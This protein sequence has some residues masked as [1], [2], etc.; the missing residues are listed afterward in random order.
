M[1]A[2]QPRLDR[3]YSVCDRV[4][5]GRRPSDYDSTYRWGGSSDDDNISADS[6]STA[7]FS[8]MSYGFGSSL[9]TEGTDVS[10]RSR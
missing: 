5:F 10:G 4:S 9:T 7:A 3:R 1:L 2:Q 6:P 8:P